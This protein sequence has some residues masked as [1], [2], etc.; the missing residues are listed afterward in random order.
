M[1]ASA[2][3]PVRSNSRTAGNVERA[4]KF[5]DLSEYPFKKRLVI[6]LAD[7]AFYGLINLIGRTIRFDVIDWQNYERATRDGGL[8][9]F[10]FWHDR[11][12]LMT[13]WWRNRRIVVLTSKSFDG[14]YIARFIQRFGYGAVRGSSTRGS[15]GA[16]VELVRLMR[17][18]CPTAFTVDGPTGPPYVAKMGPVLV[19]KKTGH[20]IVPMTIGLE[21]LWKAP[22]WDNFQ[23]PLPFSRARL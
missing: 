21:H 15:V 4:Y 22:T 9:I 19:A 8:P 18:G 12:F 16:V 20:P 2:R 23:V 13:Y 3:Q 5:A 1:Q 7:L 10:A 11:I 6:R 14:E 17:E